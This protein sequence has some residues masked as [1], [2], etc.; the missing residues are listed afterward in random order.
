MK[1]FYR[2]PHAFQNVRNNFLRRRGGSACRVP[3]ARVS[4]GA[5]SL[6]AENHICF[7]QLVPRF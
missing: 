1:M 2:F 5:A 3:P 4:V 6:I 7:G